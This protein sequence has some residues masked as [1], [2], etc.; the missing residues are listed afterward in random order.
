MSSEA[1]FRDCLLGVSFF[2]VGMCVYMA[3]RNAVA[4]W[5]YRRSWDLW[6]LLVYAGMANT[7]G[8]L[9]EILWGVPEVPFTYRAVSFGIGML[10]IF[11]GMV[12]VAASVGRHDK[13]ATDE[14]G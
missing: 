4:L 12:G 13:R 11:I 1:I 10:A 5:R 14:R 7:I 3:I 6:F 2:V 9:A 8:L